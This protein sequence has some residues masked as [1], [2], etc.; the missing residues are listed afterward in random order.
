MKAHDRCAECSHGRYK[1]DDS[2]C[3]VLGLFTFC[4]CPTFVEREE[5]DPSRITDFGVH[6]DP[7]REQS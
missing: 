2:G 7:W 1:H 4:G 5:A 3:H 6:T